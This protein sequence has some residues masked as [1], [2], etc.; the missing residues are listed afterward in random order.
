MILTPHSRQDSR[1]DIYQDQPSFTF[2]GRGWARHL[3]ALK[4]T[5][6]RAADPVAK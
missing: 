3:G 2:A 1:A 5:D 6:R 4:P